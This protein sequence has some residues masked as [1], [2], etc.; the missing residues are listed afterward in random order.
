MEPNNEYRVQ[1]YE[2]VQI[3]AMMII[4]RDIQYLP[5]HHLLL[6][7]LLTLSRTVSALLILSLHNKNIFLNWFDLGFIRGPR[8]NSNNLKA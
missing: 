3:N 8:T 5:S 6:L 7:P 4:N 1:T 2:L